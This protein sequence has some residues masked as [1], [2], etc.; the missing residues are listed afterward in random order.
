MGK[1]ITLDK[2]MLILIVVATVAVFAWSSSFAISSKY[3]NKMM[4]RV[5]KMMKQYQPNIIIT[6]TT[7]GVPRKSIFERRLHDKL[8]A[9]EKTYMN[10][11]NIQ[12][13]INIRT[14]GERPQYQSVGFLFDA[15]NSNI[16]TQRLQ[17]FGRPEYYGST[18][19]EYYI[20]DNSRNNIKIPLNNQ[21]EIFSKDSIIVPSI[22]GSY[23][24]TV[25]DNDESKYIPYLFT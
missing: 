20:I 1:K 15:T 3:S 23:V 9:P 16:E 17:L 5:R 6:N 10:T 24:A 14:R 8:E 19:Y 22:T 12:T 25:Y 18:Q 2:N 11:P 7:P 4:K 13:P 21:K